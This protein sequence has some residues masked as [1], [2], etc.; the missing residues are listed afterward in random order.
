VFKSPI[1]TGA[2][3]FQ[4]PFRLGGHGTFKIEEEPIELHGEPYDQFITDVIGKFGDQGFGAVFAFN[5]GQFGS[6]MNPYYGAAVARATNDWNIDTWLSLPDDRL[7]SEVAISTS[8]PEEAA[9]EIRRVGGHPKIHGVCIGGNQVGKPL[10]DEAH[11]PIFRAAVEMDL[12]V[13]FHGIS[14]NRPTHSTQHTGGNAA[15]IEYPA[16]FTQEAPHF[17]TSLIS[18]GVFER[19]PTLRVVI[20]E[21][22]IAFVPYVFWQLDTYY[23]ELRYESPWVKKWPS[24]YIPGHIWVTT[25]PLEESPDGPNDI[26][27][28]PASFDGMEDLLCFSTDY[29]HGPSY[30]DPF[31][32][33]RR[34]PEKWLRKVY[35]ENGCD[36]YNIPKPGLT[37]AEKA[38]AERAPVTA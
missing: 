23:E 2:S 32:I 20:K 1:Q 29:P 4:T 19:F 38:R 18:H 3:T 31:Y 14:C 28:V 36:A 8:L 7:F 9:K 10:G 22:G 37:A 33:S 17:L 25:Q 15:G 27:D 11:D 12:A 30:D 21:V 34:I 13:T 16:L 35:V 6:H 24:E 26:K 5:V